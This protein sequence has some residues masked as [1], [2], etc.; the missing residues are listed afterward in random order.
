MGSSK[1][2]TVS[3]WYKLIMHLGWCKGPIDALLEI[4][5]GDRTAWLGRQTTSGDIYVDRPDL[6][7]GE[8][9]EGGIQGTFEVMMGEPDQMPNAYLAQE[10]GPA[11]PGYRGRATVLLKGPKIGAGNPYP[12]PL[13]FKLERIYK[14]WDNGEVWYPE[15][16]QI[17]SAT[18][19]ATAL[20][21]KFESGNLSAYSVLEGINQG[22]SIVTE[23]NVKA[24]QC[25]QSP[26]RHNVLA[27]PLP[28]AAPLFR[29]RAR[30]KLTA[31]GPDDC[32][33]VALFDQAGNTVVHFEVARQDTIDPLRRPNLMFRDQ[34][35]QP[36]NPF[37]PGPVD[38]DRWYIMDATYDPTSGN[39]GCTVTATDDG[40]LFG[41]ITVNVGERSNVHSLGFVI[42]DYTGSGT[43]R[44]T[45][46]QVIVG[47]VSGYMN[48]AHILYD[49][50][51]SRRENGGMEEPTARINDESFRRAADILFAESF[52]LCCTWHGGESAEQF[53]QRI[54]NVVGASMSQSRVDGQY[55]LDLLREVDDPDELPAITDDDI[56]EWNCEPALPSESVNQVQVKWF[57]P[58]TREERITTPVQA[59]GA[60]EDAGGILADM[61]EYYEIP[62]EGLALRVAQRDL[63]SLSTALWK[64]TIT[65]TRKPFDLRPGMQM[66]L[67]CPKRGFADII[68]VIGDID[69]GDFGNDEISIVALQDVFSM[70]ASSFVD[71]QDSLAPPSNQDPN[72]IVDSVAVESPYVELA[73]AL[74]AG[75]LNAL[76]DDVGY[77]M[78]GARR[79]GNGNNYA[80]ATKTGAEEY[81][82]QA[83]GEWTPSARIVEGDI[84]FEAVPAT[85]FTFVAGSMLDNVEIGTWALWGDE[86]C[87]VDALDAGLGTITL[88]RGAADTVPHNHDPDSIIYFIGDW[89]SSD[90]REYVDGEVVYAKTMNR[91]GQAQI[92]LTDAPEVSTEIA[93]R[94]ARPY[95]PAKVR[96]NGVAYPETAF[97]DVEVTWEHRDRVL[98][99]DQLVDTEAASIGP[100]PG[101]TYSVE[102][103]NLGD[104]TLEHSETGITGNSTTP[105]APLGGIYRVEAYSVR[106]GLESFQRYIHEFSSGEAAWT[107]DWMHRKAAILLDDST[108]F[109]LASGSINEWVN[110]GWA[111]DTFSAPVSTA[112]PEL[113]PA[114]LNGRDVARFD[115]ASDVLRIAN[116]AA[117]N[118]FRNVGYGWVFVVVKSRMSAVAPANNF[119]YAP[120]SSG[121]ARLALA[122]ANDN[123]VEM[124]V[125]RLDAVGALAVSGASEALADWAMIQAEAK[126]SSAEFNIFTNGDV[127]AAQTGLTAGLTSNTAGSGN[128]LSIGGLAITNNGASWAAV[129]LAAVLAGSGPP[130]SQDEFDRITGYYAWRYGLVGL[131]DPAHPYKN[132]RPVL[133]G[134]LDLLWPSVQLQMDFEGVNAST[135]ITEETGLPVTT[136]GNAQLS[137][138]VAPPYGTSA[139]RLDGSGDYLNIPAAGPR[140]SP[141]PGKRWAVFAT[142][143]LDN[144]AAS[145]INS[146]INRR[147]S[148]SAREWALGL[149]NGVP[150][151]FGWRGGGIVVQLLPAIAPLASNTWYRISVQREE[152]GTW[153]MLLNETV[154]ATFTEADTIEVAPDVP[155]TIGR[156][157][158]NT[159]RDFHGRIK[160]LRI[161]SGYGVPNPVPHNTGPLWV[162]PW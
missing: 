95:P 155:A 144:P 17:L 14:G 110:S 54:C 43:S 113:L 104:S 55:Y 70:P 135:D 5:G 148:G 161:I 158:T 141:A 91:T 82:E 92:A 129:D 18:A 19:G 29:L 98:Q 90:S 22:F 102:F 63:Q 79:P 39:F 37:G 16:A 62:Y 112:R 115:G 116:T 71:P 8:S 76:A 41:E 25:A 83:I 1:K 21:E 120:T 44:F 68:V 127:D 51:T 52:G 136:F 93:G 23:G 103:Y 66:R 50:I 31:L 73:A 118:L 133:T 27:R 58:N 74:P 160:G 36:G 49:S 119:F 134:G 121:T 122:V 57:D 131:L 123:N 137:T 10:F 85:D 138:A 124:G 150:F 125:R 80:L 159:G 69:Y 28:S 109:N 152:D 65:C 108:G 47:V 81:E 145:R 111:G 86:I 59:L 139:L 99:A 24:I 56:I 30:F 101:T 2:I 4:R 154:V 126:W 106:D 153:M 132:E 67:Q 149:E 105:W 45:D 75:E 143:L 20:T 3:H 117:G 64:F 88:G 157:P 89:Y 114:E 128:R 38:I 156:D 15:T 33:G 94:Q 32:G 12:K 61:R 60:I 84:L 162:P 35:G 26:N 151:F 142:I 100:E 78:V 11:Q 96:I 7:G 97:G 34:S 72:N 107:P 146:V 48:P 46:V 140:F 147:T 6:Y 42:D 9:S 13:F 87:R 40:S 53:Q 130:P 77:V